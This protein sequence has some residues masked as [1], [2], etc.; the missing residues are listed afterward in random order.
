VRKDV[1]PGLGLVTGVDQ[2]AEKETEIALDKTN[3]TEE[4]ECLVFIVPI[5]RVGV[6]P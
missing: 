1:G 2:V 6:T 4:R 5:S 3:H